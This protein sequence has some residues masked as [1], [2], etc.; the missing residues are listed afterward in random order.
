MWNAL[1]F[2]LFV[3]RQHN[4]LNVLQEDQFHR[5]HCPVIAMKEHIPTKME[6]VLYVQMQFLTVRY[7]QTIQFVNNAMKNMILIKMGS[8]KRK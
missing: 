1:S 3:R 6:I 5:I 8:V 2:A 7:V 4:V